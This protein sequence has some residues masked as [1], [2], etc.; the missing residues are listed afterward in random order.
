MK[1]RIVDS[2]NEQLGARGL[3]FVESGGDL[4]IAAHTATMEQ[5]TLRSRRGHVQ[6]V[7]SKRKGGL[8]PSKKIPLRKS[9]IAEEYAKKVRMEPPKATRQES[10]LV[11]GG[12]ITAR[13]HNMNK[14]PSLKRSPA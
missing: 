5:K 10:P 6:E 12:K 9:K 1:D 14:K 11:A 4:G 8:M 2:V 13:Q 7:S 3:K